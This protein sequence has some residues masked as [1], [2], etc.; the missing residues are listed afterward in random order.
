MQHQNQISINRPEV[1]EVIEEERNSKTDPSSP[2]EQIGFENT[3]IDTPHQLSSNEGVLRLE[4]ESSIKCLPH[5]YNRGIPKTTYE[6]ELSSKVRYPMSN[7]VS[8]HR[9]FK[10][11]KSFVN[12]LSTIVIP[13][14]V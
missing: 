6:P 9:L 14:N 5:Q 8:N 7:Y 10:T 1:E 4:L 3:S 11:Y 12:Q 2:Y 13:N